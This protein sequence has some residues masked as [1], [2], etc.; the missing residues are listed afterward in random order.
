MSSTIELL[1]HFSLS[2][3]E[4][5]LYL[6]LLKQGASNVSN[7]AHL[8]K[9][10]RAAVYFH[11]DHLLQ[12][13]L[14]KETRVGRRAEYVAMPPKELGVLL[15][16]WTTD[17]KSLIP[18]LESL[19]RAERDKPIIEVI[20]SSAGMK[21]IYDEITVQP[22]GSDFLVLEGKSALR[23]ETRL[24]ANR[25]WES[26]FRRIV[27]RKILTRAVFT[28]ESME[29]PR[30]YLTEENKKIFRARRWELRSLPEATLP[31]EHL[32]MIYGDKA[33]FYIAE[34]KLLFTLKHPGI[35]GMLRV[36]FDTIHKIAQPVQGGW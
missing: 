26:F 21:R 24:M 13:G 33:A 15:E 28:K 4:A 12:R 32:M 2:P 35:V 34:S 23:G 30:R 16:R 14:V 31:F 5:E 1:Q 11:L 25:E 17:F 9:K 20:E 7:L 6:L 18:E 36:M 22:E 10:N 19:Q 3:Q 27:E 29:I 8:Q